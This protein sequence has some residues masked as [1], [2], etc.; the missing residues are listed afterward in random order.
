MGILTFLGLRRENQWERL[1][2]L[3]QFL[4]SPLT[5]ITINIYHF[6][7]FLRGQPFTPP[8]GRPAIRVVCISDTHEQFVDIPSGDILIHAGD[9][10][11]SGT[12][13]DI[14][15]QLDWLKSQPHKVKF[16]VAGNHDS[17]FDP[18]SRLDQDI[19]ANAAVNLDGLLYLESGL[20]V[21][22]IRGRKLTIFGAPDI[23][24]CGPES[25]A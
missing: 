11:Q 7:L 25:F 24:E 12:A 22:E 4:L 14:Q 5:F 21:Q 1:T 6:L 13:E 17:W 9:L 2:L 8:R 10:T 3:D 20:N 18:R 16:V 19:K 23:P 15:K